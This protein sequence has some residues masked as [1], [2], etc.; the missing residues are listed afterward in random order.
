[1]RL[2]ARVASCSIRIT[3]SGVELLV[4]E[5]QAIVRRERHPDRSIAFER[6]AL[7][8]EEFGRAGYVSAAGLDERR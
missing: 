3:C 4:V 1:M 7:L 2:D 5:Q 8:R 6:A